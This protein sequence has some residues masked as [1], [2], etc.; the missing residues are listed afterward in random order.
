MLK[1]TAGGGGIGM[2]LAR[3][4]GELMEAYAAVE[5]LSQSHF[6]QGGLYL[7]RFVESARHIEV[8]IFGDGLGRVLVLGDRDC[9]AQRR[10]QKVI[11]ETPAPGLSSQTREALHACAARLG[12]S[13]RY[14]SAGTVE[15]VYDV[16]RKAFYF[17]EVNTRLQ[18]EHGV[19]EAVTGLDLVEWMVRQAAGDLSF[20]PGT[21]P[22]SLGHAIEVRLYAEDP[23]HD[24]RPSAGRVTEVA[25]PGNVRWDG[26]IEPG[27]EV[28]PHYDPLLAKLIVHAETRDL[29]VG[30]MQKALAETRLGGLVTNLEYL[31][32]ICSQAQFRTGGITT[33][34]LST[35]AFRPQAFEVLQPGSLTTVQ[36]YPGRTGYWNVGV[37]PC[38]PMDSLS[39]RMANA[40]L[41]NRV[42]AAGLEITASGPTL[43]FHQACQICVTGAALDISLTRNE[44]G[45]SLAQWQVHDIPAGAVLR[46]GAVK[47]PGLRSYIAFAGGLVIPLYL[48]SRSTFTLGQFGG[49]NGRVLRLGD[50]IAWFPPTAAQSKLKPLAV[51]AGQRP[52]IPNSWAL[53][54]LYGPH[55]AP[56]F[57]TEDDICVLFSTAYEVH[58]QSN[59]TGIR[60]IGPKPRFARPDG[61]EAGLHPSNI[62]DN[63]YAIGAIDFTGDMPI[64]L[65]PDGPSLGGFVCPATV[66]QG[67]LWKLGQLRPG[68]TVHFEAVTLEV[69]RQL[70]C[71]QEALLYRIAEQNGL[72]NGETLPSL[73]N[74]GEDKAE[75]PVAAQPAAFAFSGD[76]LLVGPVA[77]RL[78][79]RENAPEV[80]YRRSGDRNWLIEYGPHVLDLTLRFRIHALMQCIE[81]ESWPFVVDLTPGIRSLQVHFDSLRIHPDAVLEKLI[82]LE[83]H[84]PSIA[85]MEVPTR[86]LHLPLSWNDPAI[87]AVIDKYVQV[88]RKDAPWCPSNIEFIRRINGIGTVEEVKQTLF[89]ASFMV[90]GLGDVYLGAPVATPLDPR[91][92]YVTTKYNPARTW[93]IDNVVGIGGAYM[94]IYGMEGPGGYQLFGRTS[95]VWNPWKSTGLFT[96]GRPWLLRFFDQIRFYSVT[97]EELTRFRE[98][99]LHGK[100]SIHMEESTFKLA[101]YLQF[102]DNHADS[103]SQFRATQKKA[104]VE[105][106][107][108]WIQFGLES[109]GPSESD[110]IGKE[111]QEWDSAYPD[112]V[113]TVGSPIAGNAWKVLVRQG[114]TVREGDVLAIL[115]SMK[116]EFPVVADASGLVVQVFLKEGQMV[117]S[118]QTLALL[119][120]TVAS[121]PI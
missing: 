83:S 93:T 29:A 90:L 51:E 92:R 50:Q 21:L 117:Q 107:E 100:A 119:D 44:E 15:F 69:A 113:R 9:S 25:Y 112:S 114:Q 86:I 41:G 73:P 55:G 30:A 57:F 49:H 109:S 24:F 61:G 6:K 7:E 8:Q 82:A 80:C 98:D 39:F 65:G 18:V 54:V 28:S 74:R 71:E 106:R 63:A 34:F 99:F 52:S 76:N 101:D 89:Q 31:R 66:I 2:R 17:L 48:G 37:P 121:N 40:C 22:S 108:R 33:R 102:L 12:E 45:T 84:I 118:G 60:L 85:S 87:Q 70:E 67:D 77:Y 64:L 110:P 56:D 68:D 14:A 42:D 88:V 5:R 96:K 97:P 19:T 105:E 16:D 104:F 46:L 116:M 4:S 3:H 35:L 59:R 53:K 47:G 78:P 72:P 91:H 26:W 58:F 62:H 43:L 111:R 75:V 10:N 120:P 95:Q 11:E 94:C 81:A 23:C 20:W 13:I 36:D 1:S 32:H 115:E 103:I 27:C 38:G 79:A